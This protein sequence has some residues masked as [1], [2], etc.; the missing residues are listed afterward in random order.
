MNIVIIGCGKTGARLASKLDEIGYD[1]SIIDKDKNRFE[2]LSDDFSGLCVCGEESD[3]EVLKNAGSDN[4]DAA[5]VVTESDNLNVMIARIL[6]IEFSLSD[7][8]V[9][10]LDPSRQA[11]FQKF[12]L[13]TVC[14]TK[15]ETEIL[16]SLVTKDTDSVGTLQIGDT[17]V[18]FKYTLCEKR[19]AGKKASEIKSKSREMLFAVEKKDGSIH[20]AAEAELQTSEGD[21]LIWAVI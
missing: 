2:L 6:E 7:I 11:V 14:P 12:G 13:N 8:Y 17:P 20:L 9:R 19:Q 5:V 3:V 1:V 15:L 10:L 4:A 18:R 21:R 16:F